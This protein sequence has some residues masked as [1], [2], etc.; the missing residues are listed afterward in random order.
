MWP[1]GKMTVHNHIGSFYHD[2]PG[3]PPSCP[4]TPRRAEPTP[5]DFTDAPTIELTLEE[6]ANM[7]EAAERAERAYVELLARRSK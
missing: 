5:G 4:S 6:I 7:F 2:S 1:Y 3:C